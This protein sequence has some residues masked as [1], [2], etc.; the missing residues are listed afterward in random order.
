MTTTTFD[1]LSDQQ[2]EFLAGDFDK[3]HNQTNNLL[4]IVEVI[5]WGGSGLLIG[6]EWAFLFGAVAFYIV[7]KRPHLITMRFV[8]NL[9]S[10]PGLSAF[11]SFIIM[12]CYAIT[13][14]SFSIVL[15]HGYVLIK[16]QSLS[17]NPQ[18]VTARRQVEEAQTQLLTFQKSNSHISQA[19]VDS[20]II[21]EGILK[22]KLEEAKTQA[23][24]QYQNNLNRWESQK[25]AFWNDKNPS[26]ILNADVMD[27]NCNPKRHRNGWMRTA[28]KK[29]CPK[30]Q[31]L[32]AK[33]PTLED[34]QAVQKI[35]NKLYRLNSILS[36]ND[37]LQ[38]L[39]QVVTMTLQ[40]KS[41]LTTQLRGGFNYNNGL[42]LFINVVRRL[43]SHINV[44]LF[45]FLLVGGV[46]VILLGMT[47]LSRMISDNVR[48][49]GIPQPN[50]TPENSK[51]RDNQLFKQAINFVK[52]VYDDNTSTQHTLG[53]HPN[54]STNTDSTSN[55]HALSVPPNIPINTG[56][57]HNQHTLSVPPNTPKNTSN[58]PNQ[59]A[60]SV[61]P[62]TPIDTG[63]TSNQHALGVPSNNT[64]NDVYNNI[65]IDLKNRNI[66]NLSFCSL[67]KRYRVTQQQARVLRDQ[68]VNDNF[69]RYDSTKKLVII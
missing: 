48:F 3:L 21:E 22:T 13:A 64:L 25:T 36:Y 56:N 63:N 54:I 18:I 67:Q 66:N 37:K 17:N 68:L 2:R 43:N 52:G 53:V 33:K 41:G 5:V 14:L 58:T 50:N 12:L 4:K 31:S 55:Q 1:A 62:N 29:L 30:W 19:Q 15:L 39:K 57:T 60:L 9:M 46:V 38:S 7:S 24:R 51:K 32:L 27:E 28:A 45:V 11:A 34:D 47:A 20:A 23:S 69:A 6:Y 26:G 59:H 49:Y 10:K 65:I 44:E 35:N 8:A 40:N 42:E 61:P 16:D